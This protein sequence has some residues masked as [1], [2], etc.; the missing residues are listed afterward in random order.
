VLGASQ[1]ACFSFPTN[2]MQW[3]AKLLGRATTEHTT[4]P[5]LTC[6]WRLAE[7]DVCVRVFELP[8]PCGCTGLLIQAEYYIAEL[9]EWVCIAD[10]RDFNVATGAK[11]LQRASEFVASLDPA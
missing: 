6:V 3:I 1:D 8:L 9:D 11:L 7:D 5:Q 4:E 10:L 2:C